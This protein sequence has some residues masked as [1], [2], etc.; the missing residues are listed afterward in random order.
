[1]RIAIIGAGNVGT[2]LGRGW[3]RR[4]HQV[5]YGV[6]D[7]HSAKAEALAQ[8]G[9]HVTVPA[10]AVERSEVVVPAACLP[11][12]AHESRRSNQAGNHRDHRGWLGHNEETKDHVT[13]IPHVAGDVDTATTRV[14]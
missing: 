10:Q 2:T 1:M 13:R 6:R 9:V 3:S 11:P 5:S 14:P 4:R 12:L 7:P 8:G